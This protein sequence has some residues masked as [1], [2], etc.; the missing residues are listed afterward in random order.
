MEKESR[1]GW[2]RLAEANGRREKER[3]RSLSQEESIRI[4]EELCAIIHAEFDAVPPKSRP[5][6]LV[7]YWKS[8]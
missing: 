7:K 6:G 5:V 1:C 4:L 3:L 8:R 2:E